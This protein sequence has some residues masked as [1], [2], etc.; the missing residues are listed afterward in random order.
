[1]TV[2]PI[3]VIGGGL[4]GSEAAW[5]IAQSGVPVV[6]HEMRP[7]RGTAA[8][9]T[10]GLAELV[11]SNSFRSDD[12]EANAVGLLHQ[13]MRRLGSLV[14]QKGDAHQVPA[15]GALAV[16]R[17]GFSAA[18]TAAL[19]AH[20]LITIER[21]E[22]AGLPPQEWSSAIVATG[23]LTSPAL[24]EAI[25]SLTGEKELAFFDAIAPIVY[26]ESIDMNV[27]WFQSRYDKVGPGGTGADYINCPMNRDQYE[28][29]VDALVAG[30]KTSFKEWEGTPYF[31]GCLPIEVMA[32]RGRETLRHGPMKPFGLTN[33]HNPGEKA[34]AVVQLRQDNALGTLYNMVGFQTKLRHGE[35]T[36]IF[37][38][39]PGLEKA[40]FARLG[41]LHRNTYLNSPKLLD[42]TLRLRAMPR[43][44]FAGQITGCEGYVESAAV[45]LMAG[46]FAAA[47]RLG[48]TLEP[49][50]ATTALGALINHI[51]GG[52]IETIDEGPRSFQP[53]NV[54]FGLFPPLERA[55]KAE[56]GKRLRGAAKAIAKKKALTGRARAEL[57]VWLGEMPVAVAAE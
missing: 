3:H 17:D 46:R 16:D 43:L 23:P 31:D 48:R 35:Q 19:E 33:P 53:M 5:Q 6:L 8:H 45:G 55:P 14:M 26:R 39:I 37:R 38:M 9:K 41:G 36:R 7:L 40:E 27:A 44:R 47:E 22:V 20:P 21:G 57:S 29:F 13:E 11:C 42:P 15:G 12:A 56:D 10:D 1:M 24:A 32:E 34:Y 54:N 2:D 51:T 52:H 4:A 49:L 28:A 25:L 18:V 30:D 50:P